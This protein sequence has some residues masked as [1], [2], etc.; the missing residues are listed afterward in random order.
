MDAC[1]LSVIMPR[2]Y[3]A[4]MGHDSCGVLRSVGDQQSA[5]HSVQQTVMASRRQSHF[6][7]KERS[8]FNA[9][10]VIWIIVNSYSTTGS[11]CCTFAARTL[12]ASETR[13]QDGP[14]STQGYRWLWEFVCVKGAVRSVTICVFVL[15]LS[16]CVCEKETS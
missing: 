3:L 2:V 12:Q 4:D 8:L 6:E 11:G 14:W 10:D 9:I 16:V 13:E 7:E 5:G 1:G 15:F